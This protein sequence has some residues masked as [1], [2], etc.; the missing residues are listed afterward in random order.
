MPAQAPGVIT[1]Q[2]DVGAAVGVGGG[3]RDRLGGWVAGAAAQHSTVPW[4][5]S[6]WLYH[7][8]AV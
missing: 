2:P 8:L 4:S 6:S 7:F 3:E 5:H 1:H